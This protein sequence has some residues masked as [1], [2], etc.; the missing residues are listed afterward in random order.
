VDVGRVD[1]RVLNG[2]G[3]CG[4]HVA[5]QQHDALIWELKKNW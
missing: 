2:A 5:V 1:G 4:H 3:Q